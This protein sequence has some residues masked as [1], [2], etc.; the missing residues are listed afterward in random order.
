[1]AAGFRNENVVGVLPQRFVGVV[2]KQG[3]ELAID[4]QNLGARA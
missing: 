2:A 4:V 3:F 1:M